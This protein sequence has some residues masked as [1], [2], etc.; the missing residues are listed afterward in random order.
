MKTIIA[1][2]AIAIVAAF[3][4]ATSCAVSADQAFEAAKTGDLKTIE[5]YLSGKGDANATDGM[6]N[7]LA[8][9]AAYNRRTAVLKALAD[10]GADLSKGNGA[11]LAPLDIAATVNDAES[12]RILL[13]AGA[14]P[15]RKNA[16]D[17]KKAAIHYAAINAATGVASLLLDRGVDINSRCGIGATPVTWAAFTSTLES[18]KLFVERGADLTVVDSYGDTALSSA[19]ESGRD[20]I[21]RYL[22]DIGVTR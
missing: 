15:N 9:V 8:H 10:S 6:K 14:D 13:D 11:G 22:L 18:V 12:A 7:A 16:L 21:Y 1:R 19:K 2:A 17:R 5:R 20:D 3:A 4:L